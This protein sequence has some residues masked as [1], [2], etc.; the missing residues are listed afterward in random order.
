MDNVIKIKTEHTDELIEAVL[1]RKKSVH[2]AIFEHYKGVS[3]YILTTKDI[4][5]VFE[6]GKEFGIAI[7]NAGKA[8]KRRQPKE[9]NTTRGKENEKKH[10]AEGGSEAQDEE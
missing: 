5:G 3:T 10:P 1:V 6:L 8:E 9:G 4:Q 2:L 7:A